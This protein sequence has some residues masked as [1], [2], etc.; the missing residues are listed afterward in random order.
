MKYTRIHRLMKIINLVQ[1]KR[2]LTASAL[3]ELCEV[4]ERSIYRDIN[5]LEGA[6]IP[7]AFDPASSGYRIR[8]DFFLPPVQLTPEEALALAV[9][10]EHFGD[11]EQIGFMSAASRA[12]AKIQANMPA[13]V[14]EEIEKLTRSV[15]IRTA[16][17][18]PPDEAQDVYQR[19][20]HAIATRTSV[21]CRYESVDSLSADAEPG[22]E[23]RLDPYVLFF[24]VR[25]WY[26][27]G[28][29]HGR[30]GVRSLKLGRFSGVKPTTIAYTMEKPFSLDE[31]LGNAWRMVRGTPEYEVEIVFDRDHAMTMSETLWHKTQQVEEHAD[32]TATLRCT[33]S[34]LD[35]IK[36]WVLSHG[37]HCRVIRPAE[38]AERVAKLARETA[39]QYQGR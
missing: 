12:M 34:G 4:D 25:A 1:G 29:H 37:P 16:Q 14:R 3:A 20:Q 18:T 35:E 30:Q 21:M 33:V 10:C 39:A 19:L 36:W 28:Y 8:D 2:G 38:L 31:Y 7:L 23:F 6:G 15:A 5:E 17:A 9:L 24:S 13:S 26:V 32:G 27:I 11:S 22:P